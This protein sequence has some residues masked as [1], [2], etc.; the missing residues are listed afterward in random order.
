MEPAHGLVLS[1]FPGIDLLGRAFEHLG[2]CVVRGPDTLWGGDIRRFQPQIGQFQGIIGGSP[3]QDYSNARR[4]A[5]T[6]YGDAMLAE[7]H[8]CVTQAAPLWWMLENVPGVPEMRINGYRTQ[9]IHIRASEFGGS[10]HR[11]RIIQFGH[12]VTMPGLV[13]RRPVTTAV[14]TQPAALAT[15]G[16]RANRRGWAEFCAAQGLP[17]PLDMPGLTIEARYRAVGNGVHL[18]MGHAMAT[19]IHAWYVTP[20]EEQPN[21]CEC[22]CGRPVRGR[23]YAEASCRKRAQRSRDVQLLRAFGVDTKTR[24]KRSWIT[25][26][27]LAIPTI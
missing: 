4:T 12:P 27:Q 3:C 2:F 17:E 18:D 5:P 19:A 25:S 14:V 24:H 15:E 11:L 8:R 23:R 21:T 6:G 13:I 10:S 22:E 7:F 9:R 20:P 1:L 26:G 16:K